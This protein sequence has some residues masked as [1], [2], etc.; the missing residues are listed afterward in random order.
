MNDKCNALILKQTDYRENDALILAYCENYGLLT[1]VARGIRKMSSKN[2]GSLFPFT[3]SELLFDYTEGK[4]M[5]ALHSAH[6]ISSYRSLQSNLTKSAAAGVI[7]EL[8]SIVGREISQDEEERAYLY[9]LLK[10]V[11]SEMNQSSDFVLA[12]SLFLSNVLSLLGISP[13]VDGCAVCGNTKVVAISVEQG[14][15]VC[16]KCA[17]GKSEDV[18][19]LKQF[20]LINKA[21]AEHMATLRQFAPYPFAIAEYL[22]QFLNTYLSVQLK[23]WDFLKEINML[24]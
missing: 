5:F 15:F 8:T 1:F 14:G 24:K 2:A 23:S 7:V 22:Y 9:E 13:E 3:L 4:D 18:S 20:R 12:L 6:M 16:S 11:L 19:L 21:R 17:N 10:T